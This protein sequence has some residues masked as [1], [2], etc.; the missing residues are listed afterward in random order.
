MPAAHAGRPCETQPVRVAEVTRGLALAQATAQRLD[1]SGASVV[2]LAR[3]GQDLSA[4]GLSWSHLGFAY[5]DTAGSSAMPAVWRVVHKLN[6]CGTATAQLYRQGLGEFFLD[7]PFRYE[8]AFSVPTPEVQARLLPLL[9]DSARVANWHSPAYNLVAYPWATRYQ[10]SNQWAI[11][12]L[13]GALDDG[14]SDRPR[15]QAWLQLRDYQPGRLHL[16]A[17]TRLGARMSA[18]NVAFD[19][20]PNA[21]RFADR[22]DTVTADSVFSWLQRAGL[23]GAAQVVR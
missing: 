5:K 20:H 18:A 22:I 15:A 9:R 21:Q 16:S 23:A 13:A 11:E 12:T 8:A 14:A 1:A 6:A 2:V 17:M 3:A 10:Q 7:R 19:D 4:Y